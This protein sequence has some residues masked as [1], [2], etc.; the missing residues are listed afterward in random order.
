LKDASA[1]HVTIWRVHRGAEMIAGAG[2]RYPYVHRGPY[3]GYR[4]GFANVTADVLPALLFG[5]RLTTAVSLAIFVA[6]YLELA[7]LMGGSIRLRD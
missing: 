4:R 5:V 2:P 1:L 7:P 6:F 3:R